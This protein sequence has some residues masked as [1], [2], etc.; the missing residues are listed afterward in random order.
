MKLTELDNELGELLMTQKGINK[1]ELSRKYG[2]TRNTIRSH[3]KSFESPPKER[4]RRY[5]GILKYDSFIKDEIVKHNPTIKALYM[6]LLNLS[7]YDE[8]GSYSN[9]KQYIELHY[10]DLRVEQ[11][12]KIAKYRFETPPG[13]QLQFD[14]IERLSLHLKDG[15]LV[16]F[17][18]WN[19]TLGFSRFHVYRCVSD[20]TELTF[21][22]SL[23]ETLMILKGK[24]LKLLTDNMSAIVS[25][26]SG[27]RYIHPTVTQFLKDLGIKLNLCK[28]R[29]SYTKGKVETSNKYQ[30]WIDPYDFKFETKED[31]YMGINQI[32]NQ[33]NYQ[34]NGETKLAPIVL[35]ELE[36]RKL[37]VLPSKDLL[38]KYH[39]NFITLKVNNASLIEYNGAKYGVP[40]NYINK[41][42][43]GSIDK[44]YISIYNTDLILISKYPL[45]NSGIYY[46]KGLYNLRL[47]KNETIESYNERI[48]NNLNQISKLNKLKEYINNYGEL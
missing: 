21:R 11:K 13:E 9:F 4:K 40:S 24:P 3:I 38:I 25:I 47:N 18:I 29:H 12:E 26:K 32:L 22:R 44:D 1:S 5:C 10:K 41:T 6:E 20:V 17:N 34:E 2:V 8:I 39:S 23:I 42:V 27:H 7:T 43:L 48:N 35:F 31:L 33:S 14:W 46:A 19:A 28:V 36:K 37:G 15:S 16:S 45:Y 30:N